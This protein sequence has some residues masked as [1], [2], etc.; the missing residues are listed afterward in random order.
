[1][2]DTRIESNCQ[3]VRWRLTPVLVGL[4][5]GAVLMLWPGIFAL[6]FCVLLS[7]QSCL[8]EVGDVMKK[9]KRIVS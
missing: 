9:G 7:L 6:L 3:L 2:A 1:M 5:F 4:V 8:T